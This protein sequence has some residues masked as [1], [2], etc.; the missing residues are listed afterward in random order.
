[1]INLASDRHQHQSAFV[2]EFVA[3]GFFHQATNLVALDE[4]M[5]KQSVTA[6]LGF[7]CTASSLHVGNL[8]QIMILRLLQKHGH[9]PLVLVGGG[10]TRIGDPSGKDEAR[11]ML[12]EEA[13]ASNL[14]GIRQ[15]FAPFIEFGDGAGKAKLVNNA[16]WLLSLGYIEFLRDYG[17]HFSVNRML[18]MDSVRLRLDREQNL[19]FLEFNYMLLQSYDYHWLHKQHNCQLQIGG[20][21]Q[22]GNIISGVDLVRRVAQSEVYGLTS[23][24]ITTASGAKMGKSAAGA[25]WLN[26]DMLS[27]YDYW[28]FWRNVEDKDVLRFLK[29]Y[30]DT[31]LEQMGRYE[32]MAA[33]DINAVKKILATEATRLC[34]GEDAALQA[35]ETAEKLFEMGTVSEH[36]PEMVIPE[37]TLAPSIPIYELIKLV[38]LAPSNSEARKLIRGGGAKI[39]GQTISE[40]SMLVSKDHFKN[41]QLVLS[42]GKKRHI[43]VKIA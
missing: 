38:Q 37:A 12:T 14:Q 22:W 40:E 43:R 20:S 13:I 4:L 23:P 9:T 39:D 24:L 32:E 34:H 16:D 18:T 21:D 36:M 11:Q 30:T 26:S 25:I 17:R 1:M 5:A 29:L 15:S 7:D 2:Q 42:A 35:Q 33:K 27:A 6:Y 8:M 41:G 28:Q 10:T 19:S 3:R 31:P